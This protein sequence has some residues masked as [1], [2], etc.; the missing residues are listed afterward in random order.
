MKMF[1]VVWNVGF[2]SMM[3]VGLIGLVVQAVTDVTR[4]PRD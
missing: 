4:W 2:G 1:D 3:L